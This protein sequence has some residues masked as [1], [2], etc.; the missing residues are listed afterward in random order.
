MSHDVRKGENKSEEPAG[1]DSGALS[2]FQDHYTTQLDPNCIPPKQRAE[3][4]QL[5]RQIHESEWQTRGPRDPTQPSPP[6][7]LQHH[8]VQQVGLI[9]GSADRQGAASRAPLPAMPKMT[10]MS[11]NIGRGLN[12]MNL[13]LPLSVQDRPAPDGQVTSQ[14]A[15]QLKD[16]Q[17]ANGTAEARERLLRQ[18]SQGPSEASQSMAF[19]EEPEEAYPKARSSG[20]SGQRQLRGLQPLGRIVPATFDH[21]QDRR[22]GLALMPGAVLRKMGETAFERRQGLTNRINALNLE[23]GPPDMLHKLDHRHKRR[24]AE[25]EKELRRT[26]RNSWRAEK[27]Q[28]SDTQQQPSPTPSVAEEAELLE[29]SQPLQRML[30]TAAAEDAA[31]AG[32]EARMQLDRRRKANSR[33]EEA[34][35]GSKDAGGAS[36]F[37]E[38]LQPLVAGPQGVDRG[39]P[40]GLPLQSVGGSAKTFR[41]PGVEE[42]PLDHGEDLGLDPGEQPMTK[43]L[44]MQLSH[45]DPKLGEQP[46]PPKSFNALVTGRSAGAKLSTD[47]V[48]QRFFA[49]ACSEQP[50]T[51]ATQWPQAAGNSYRTILANGMNIPPGAVAIPVQAQQALAAVAAAVAARARPKPVEL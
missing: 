15:H 25:E 10:K 19:V 17:A 29:E 35:P 3:A 24:T 13:E 20:E 36:S 2:M 18:T 34:Q 46:E 42:V 22:A 26:L 43:Q 44:L 50:S 1:D 31:A 49:A 48:L 39:E 4:D 32:A 6:G 37:P 11:A 8:E 33:K 14:L 16:L 21:E 27:A 23:P 28:N 7:A 40:A 12:A 30:L 41:S 38:A 9:P 51:A 47:A 45:A 5:A